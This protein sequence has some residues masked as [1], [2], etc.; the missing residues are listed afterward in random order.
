MSSAVQ[1]RKIALPRR[2]P[3]PRSHTSTAR[4]EKSCSRDSR[5]QNLTKQE[6]LTSHHT[7]WLG[8]CCCCCSTQRA[9]ARAQP[10]GPQ[11]REPLSLWTEAWPICA[12]DSVQHNAHGPNPQAEA[13]APHQ[14]RGAAEVRPEFQLRPRRRARFWQQFPIPTNLSRK[15][16]NMSDVYSRKRAPACARCALCSS[17]TVHSLTIPR[18]LPST[19]RNAS[20]YRV[21]TQAS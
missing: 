15:F 6:D 13:R 12:A 19:V 5:E 4:R 18:L 17:R 9:R 14:M 2:R 11:A 1:S 7:W 8:R 16:V 3:G 20:V 21:I 10:P